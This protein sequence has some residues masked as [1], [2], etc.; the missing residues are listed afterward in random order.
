MI[1]IIHHI[2]HA[3]SVRYSLPT[4]HNLVPPTCRSPSRGRMDLATATAG[5]GT[6]YPAMP[7]GTVGTKWLLQVTATH[8][9]RRES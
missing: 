4:P 7:G 6:R 3:V 9:L 1:Y 8:Q 2:V 5:T